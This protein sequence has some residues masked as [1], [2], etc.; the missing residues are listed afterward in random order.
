MATIY[1]TL[2]EKSD[3]LDL[4]E[5]RVRFKHGKIDQQSKTNIFKV[6]SIYSVLAEKGEVFRLSLFC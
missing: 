6:S 4:K 5:I 2:S 3:T 1:L